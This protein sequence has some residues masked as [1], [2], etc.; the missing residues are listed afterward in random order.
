M[1]QDN[2]IQHIYKIGNK[3]NHH[4]SHSFFPIRFRLPYYAGRM[5]NET[6]YKLL[7]HKTE[8]T[9]LLRE[10]E[11]GELRATIRSNLKDGT[12]NGPKIGHIPISKHEDGNGWIMGQNYYPSILKLVESQKKIESAFQMKHEYKLQP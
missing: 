6:A 4:Y 7:S 9:F 12:R 8:G 10:N 3:S 2:Y 11:K 5:D 1:I